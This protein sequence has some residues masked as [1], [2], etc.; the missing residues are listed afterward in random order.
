M[1]PFYKIKSMEDFKYEK[2]K[3]K[4]LFR[5]NSYQV[6]DW[7]KFKSI[8][9]HIK[10]KM[11]Q[12]IYVEKKYEAYCGRVTD[13]SREGFLGVCLNK[14]DKR[15][16]FPKG[17]TI[18]IDKRSILQIYPEK[19]VKHIT[20]RLALK[21]I[22]KDLIF[23]EVKTTK[24]SNIR[25]VY[26]NYINKSGFPRTKKFS[27]YEDAV[28]NVEPDYHRNIRVHYD[29]YF[30]FTGDRVVRNND[31]Y[32]DKE[33]FFSKKCYSELDWADKHPTGDFLLNERAFNHVPPKPGSLICGLVENGE[34]GLFFRKWFVCSREFLLLWTMIC[35]PKDHSL[36]ENNTPKLSFENLQSGEDISKKV[37]V[38]IK[39][40]YKLLRELSTSGY[41]IDLRKDLKE[42]QRKYIVYNLERGALYYSNRYRKVA[43]IVFTKGQLLNQSLTDSKSYSDD[44][45]D[46]YTP[47]QKRL[48]RNILWQK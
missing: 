20:P 38:R 8:R 46:D 36:I 18:W 21:H 47:F 16:D 2:I 28:R 43:E 15:M 22:W 11:K 27:S 23:R 10:E 45:K 24:S 5:F 9:P 42:R 4:K 26:Y 39:P 25:G 12:G 19:I 1:I 41:K 44:Y 3:R 13:T 37:V 40:F 31:P 6:G 32:Y 35:D 48:I 14:E 34:K 33:I 17:L 29:E 7:V 30:G